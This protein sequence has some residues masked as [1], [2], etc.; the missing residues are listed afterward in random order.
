MSALGAAVEGGRVPESSR[1][2]RDG[3]QGKM[4]I[5]GLEQNQQLLSG[6]FHTVIFGTSISEWGNYGDLRFQ[7]HIGKPKN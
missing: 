3:L 4:K 5:V 6:G 7:P 1:E 2:P